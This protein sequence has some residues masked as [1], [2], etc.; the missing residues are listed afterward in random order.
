MIEAMF[1]IENLMEIVKAGGRIKTG[2]DVY[3]EK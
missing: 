1:S 3:N 2:V